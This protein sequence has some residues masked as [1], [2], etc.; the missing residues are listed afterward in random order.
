MIMQVFTKNNINFLCFSYFFRALL[1][2]G[3]ANLGEKN[4][5]LIAPKSEGSLRI[6]KIK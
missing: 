5:I 6:R 3:L 2:D 4:L 1:P